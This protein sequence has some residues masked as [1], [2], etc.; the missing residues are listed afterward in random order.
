M[1]RQRQAGEEGAQ[2]L[3]ARPCTPTWKGSCPLQG[4][5]EDAKRKD[6]WLSS[7]QLASV[8]SSP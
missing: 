1:E 8:V 2:Q 6:L 3:Q 5:R 7:P 4:Q